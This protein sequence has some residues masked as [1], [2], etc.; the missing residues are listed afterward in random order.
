[1]PDGCECKYEALPMCS[2]NAK[3]LTVNLPRFKQQMHPALAQWRDGLG[4]YSPPIGRPEFH[5]RL[6][7]WLRHEL[8][9]NLVR[10]Y[11]GSE[12]AL[13]KVMRPPDGE[14]CFALL[15]FLGRSGCHEPIVCRKDVRP[16][17]CSS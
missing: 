17:L 5:A 2:M 4:K 11:A 8:P 16:R 1:M 12:R 13:H 9:H 15:R 3:Q 10:R 14:R 6:E 7:A